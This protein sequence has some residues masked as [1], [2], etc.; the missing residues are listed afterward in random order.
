MNLDFELRYQTMAVYEPKIV[1]NEF[2]AQKYEVK[3]WKAYKKGEYKEE[4]VG[5]KALSE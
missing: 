5:Q 1:K 3:V 4:W 2:F